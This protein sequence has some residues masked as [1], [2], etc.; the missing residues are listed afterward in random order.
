[1]IPRLDVGR[2][3]RAACTSGAVAAAILFHWLARHCPAWEPPVDMVETE[4]EIFVCVALPGVSAQ[5]IEI[6]FETD[7]LVISGERLLPSG[8]RAA[9]IHRLE[10]PHGR[11]ERRVALPSEAVEL[12][13][14]DLIDGCLTL[15]C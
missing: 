7:S 15:T 1:M 8:M 5:Q 13:R 4:R 9:L 3:V 11:F 6:L 12:K 10:I 2:S 14:R